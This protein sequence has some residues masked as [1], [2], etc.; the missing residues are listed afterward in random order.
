MCTAICMNMG[1]FFFGRTLDVDREY[2]QSVVITPKRFDYNF[3]FAPQKAKFD[4]LGMAAVNGGY[5]LYFDAVNEK[6]LCMA[7]LRFPE[8][9][10]SNAPLKDKIN[11]APFEF[12][13]FILATCENTKEVRRVLAQLNLVHSDFSKDLPVSPLHWMICDKHE[14]LVVESTQRG[15]EV[16]E[17]PV[18]VLT[19]SPPFP[20]HL[21]NLNNYMSLSPRPARNTFSDQ[22]N[23]HNYSFG[24]G[25]L[26]LPG[27]LSSTSRF[28]RATYYKH[29]VIPHEN[30]LHSFL[31]VLDTC[32]QPKGLTITDT[33][34][35]EYTAYT[36]CCNAT[37][38]EYYYKLYGSDELYCLSFKS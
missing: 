34:E 26:G 32:Y 4:V 2:G 37:K 15:L 9:K 8:F 38:G 17:N 14:C 23:L 35:Y 25:A 21:Y 19:N 33:G 36:S 28:V 11:V 10:C 24:M 20:F 30:K 6:G 18:G 1:D 22:L 7:G 31:C 5:P 29:N 27:D 13:P 3:R 16:F 12:I